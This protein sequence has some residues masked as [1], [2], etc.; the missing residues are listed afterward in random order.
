MLLLSNALPAARSV[1]DVPGDLPTKRVLG[2]GDVDFD[3]D[4]SIFAMD[5]VAPRPCGSRPSGMLVKLFPR[6]LVGA[7]CAGLNVTCVSAITVSENSD[8]EPRL[9][10]EGMSK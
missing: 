8:S 4:D 9:N 10:M 7:F 3:A 6:D 5:V 1:L 2:S